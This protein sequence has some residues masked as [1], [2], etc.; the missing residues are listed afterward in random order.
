MAWNTPLKNKALS[1]LAVLQ[2][3][4]PEESSKAATTKV[5]ASGHSKGKTKKE[6]EKSKSQNGG[7]SKNAS[8]KHYVANSSTKARQ[9]E[10]YNFVPF[11]DSMLLSPLNDKIKKCN[12]VKSKQNAFQEYIYEQ[13]TYSGY[14]DVTISNKTPMLINMNSK[15]FAVGESTVKLCIPG[16]SVRGCVKNIFKIMASCGWKSDKNN[17]DFYDRKLYFRSIYNGDY[18]RIAKHYKGKMLAEGS[19]IKTKAGFLVRNK[20][21]EYFIIPAELIKF[22][23]GQ[24]FDWTEKT[25][26]KDKDG[27]NL[28]V[29]IGIDPN[30]VMPHDGNGKKISV[31]PGIKWHDN[32][33]DVFSGEINGKKKFYRISKPNFSQ[34]ASLKI[35]NNFIDLYL[36]DVNRNGISLIGDS[37]EEELFNKGFAIKNATIK[38][39]EESVYN[40]YGD[41]IYIFHTGKLETKKQPLA[42]KKNVDHIK[43]E[44]IENTLADDINKFME[45][46]KDDLVRPTK[47]PKFLINE[48]LDVNLAETYEYIVPCFYVDEVKKENNEEKHIVTSFGANPYYRINYNMSIS[49]HLPEAFVKNNE[50]IDYSDAIFGNKEGWGS[51]VFF[52]DF[53]ITEDSK[54]EFEEGIMKPLMIP[55]PTS[56]QNYLKDENNNFACH[57]DDK[58]AKLRGYKMYWHHKKANWIDES[59]SKADDA[60]HKQVSVLKEM[61]KFKGR[62]RFENLTNLELGAIAKVFVLGNENDICF[63][64]G[65]GKPLGLGSIDFKSKLYIQEK[66]YYHSLFNKEGSNFNEATDVTKVTDV[67]LEDFINLFDKELSEK[68]K[69]TD[70]ELREILTFTKYGKIQYTSMENSAK[71]NPLPTISEVVKPKK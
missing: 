13:P 38:Y 6:F 58:K 39:Q 66:N 42:K 31:Q 29:Y 51:R 35:D 57:W 27:N 3:Q 15:F 41:W 65:M 11:G 47:I 5:Q 25:K 4:L 49:E 62:I 68:Q 64:I 69:D 21:K 17:A 30:Y 32:Y 7:K 48:K 67:K 45:Y 59:C 40:H 43:R 8:N 46:F 20:E 2:G 22:P 26:Q 44:D 50:E 12:D 28:L 56:F 1:K 24:K 34:N 60:M 61:A 16:S 19:T 14:F 55:N 33:V 18:G 9:I 63:K 10:P 23:T 54:A 37:N 53:Y 36:D 71:R 52:E 70:A